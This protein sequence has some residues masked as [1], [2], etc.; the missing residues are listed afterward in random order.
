MTEDILH[1]AALKSATEQKAY[2]SAKSLKNLDTVGAPDLYL[3]LFIHTA[4]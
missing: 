3:V 4:I 2:N 1:E